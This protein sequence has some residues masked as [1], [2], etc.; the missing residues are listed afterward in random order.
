[1]LCYTPFVINK[2]TGFGKLL[3]YRLCLDFSLFSSYITSS[4]ESLSDRTKNSGK[5][6]PRVAE[7]TG[8]ICFLFRLLFNVVLVSSKSSFLKEKNHERRS[9]VQCIERWPRYGSL[10]Q[11]VRCCPGLDTATRKQ[12]QTARECDDDTLVSANTAII[13]CSA[14]Y[15]KQLIVHFVVIIFY[16]PY[17][18]LIPDI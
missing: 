3:I 4:Q 6:V 16:I 14:L 8:G 17:L 1:M 10:Q 11:D 2:L 13:V 15:E 5:T 12:R 7:I 9:E 18:K